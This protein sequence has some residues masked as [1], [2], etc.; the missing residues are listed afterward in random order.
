MSNTKMTHSLQ[1]ILQ[2]K[3]GAFK[4]YFLHSFQTTWVWQFTP[5]YGIKLEYWK[6]LM[7]K[8][9][10]ENS[11]YSYKMWMGLC[12]LSSTAI[13]STLIYKNQWNKRKEKKTQKNDYMRCV[14]IY[15]YVKKKK[16]KGTPSEHKS[17][18]V[19]RD[20]WGILV[21]FYFDINL[22]HVNNCIYS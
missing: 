20:K 22:I 2:S 9:I 5:S 16:K 19:P 18:Q 10:L 8:I 17:F 15:V 11:L 6:P 12:I 14:C 21:H 1:I 13:L 3:H 4:Y 7:V